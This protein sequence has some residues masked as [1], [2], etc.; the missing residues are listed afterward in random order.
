MAKDCCPGSLG[1]KLLR[2]TKRYSL[3][4]CRH[5]APN[6]TL[7]IEDFWA[8]IWMRTLKLASCRWN[9]GQQSAAFR[10]TWLKS[11]SV[12]LSEAVLHHALSASVHVST[13]ANFVLLGFP[14]GGVFDGKTQGAN[15]RPQQKINGLAKFIYCWLLGSTWPL[16]ESLETL[17]GRNVKQI[18]NNP[19]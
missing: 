14:M 2:T 7:P 16:Y 9:F 3:R 13:V 6:P 19:V 4:I 1:M 5:G 12:P 11:P 15:G 17:S 8:K 18:V 10:S